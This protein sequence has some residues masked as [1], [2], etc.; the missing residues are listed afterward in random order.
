MEDFDLCLHKDFVL[1]Q[2]MTQEEYREEGLRI[3][4]SFADTPFGKVLISS[5][6]R[7][8]CGLVFVENEINALVELQSYFPKAL[9]EEKTEELHQRVMTFFNIN[10]DDPEKVTLHVQATDFQYEV[11]TKLLDIPVG[12]VISYA[13]MAK[14]IGKEK[15]FRAVGIAIGRNPIAFVIPCHRVVSSASSLNGYRWGIERKMDILH[16]EGAISDLEDG[17]N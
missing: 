17:G 15:Y 9:L 11:W 1:M 6:P 5:T 7:G 2:R 16:W 10:V 4:Y 8:I 3:S 13:S 12:S 14:E